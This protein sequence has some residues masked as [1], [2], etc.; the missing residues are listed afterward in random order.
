MI[1][2]THRG[3]LGRRVVVVGG[4]RGGGWSGPGEVAVA[5]DG[6]RLR[7]VDGAEAAVSAE[8]AGGPGQAGPPVLRELEHRLLRVVQTVR[9]L[10]PPLVPEPVSHSL[11][12]VGQL[13]VSPSSG[14]SPRGTVRHRSGGLRG[15]V[16][17]TSWRTSSA[18]YILSGVR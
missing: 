14:P 15:V 18:L 2:S 5:E 11:D 1:D 3:R 4:G 16:S 12:H 9:G 10:A 7:P 8:H 6:P 13:P 17:S